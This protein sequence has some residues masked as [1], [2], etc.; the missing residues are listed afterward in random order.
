LLEVAL[1]RGASGGG[2]KQSAWVLAHV[3]AFNDASPVIY[4]PAFPANCLVTRAAVVIAQAFDDPA[5]TLMLGI[6]S[7]PHLFLDTTDIDPT[8]PDTY[9]YP[10]IVAVVAGS[11]QLTINP[12]AATR[13]VGFVY[14]EAA[15]L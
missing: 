3:F 4:T 9:S 14:T 11:L 7:A 5:A 15:R 10:G 8:T 13:G 6:P 1:A 2:G 12:A